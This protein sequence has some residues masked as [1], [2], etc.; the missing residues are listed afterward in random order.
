MFTLPGL[1]ALLVAHYTKVN[2]ISQSLRPLPVMNLL[3]FAAGFGLLLDLRLRLVRAEACPQLRLALP[4]WLWTLLSVALTGAQIGR[5]A[6]LTMIYMLL[7]ILIAQGV[8]SFRALRAVALTILATSLFLGVVAAIQA[9]TPFECQSLVASVTGDAAGRPDGR[10]CQSPAECREG[11]EDAEDY[12]CERP[13]PFD[14]HSVAHGRVRYRGIL[15]DPNELA[16][17]LVIALPFAMMT[18]A[19][20]SLISILLSGASFAIVLPAVVW[21]ASRTGQLAFI[22]VVAVYWVQ[23][24]GWKGLLA[25][26]VLA[27][28]ALLLGGRSGSEA[29]ESAM[30]RLEAWSAGMTMFKSSPIWGVGKS[31]FLEHHVL[32]AHNTVMLEAAELGL[33]GM[34]LWVG[35]LYTGFKITLVALRRYGSRPDGTLA[36]DWARAL[37][38]SLC[39]IAVGTS[40]LSLGYHPLVWAF[41]ALPGAYYL[42]VRRRDPEFHVV[43]GVRD[44]LAVG[45]LGILYLVGV[46]GYLL[47]RGI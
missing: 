14:T 45:A 28:P 31:Q 36:S 22:A 3:Y 7:F 43:F 9:N 26:A 20:R 46:Q 10:S 29:D 16:L 15:E 2:E 30:E 17:A 42:T 18:F 25:A 44:L 47:I 38:A 33:V 5:Q 40:F 13:G 12:I 1:L 8:Q 41:L 11:T 24:V 39:G 32:T 23:R 19:R 37:L 34:L 27:A 35:I 4:L 6:V 21:T